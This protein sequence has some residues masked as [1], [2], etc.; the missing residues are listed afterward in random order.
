MLNGLI[1]IQIR[2]LVVKAPV[3][4]I[5]YFGFELVMGVVDNML[6]SKSSTRVAS[7]NNGDDGERSG[8]SWKENGHDNARPQLNFKR[9]KVSAV[10]DFPKG[11]GRSA[12][13]IGSP[14]N[15]NIAN[16]GAHDGTLV[17]G[18]SVED[19]KDKFVST[20]DEPP[21]AND[22]SSKA[23]LVGLEDLESCRNAETVKC[24]SS[25]MSKDLHKNGPSSPVDEAVLLASNLLSRIVSRA[26]DKTV[27]RRNFPKRRVSAT[28]HFPPFCGRNAPRLSKDKLEEL[29]SKDNKI[30]G[31]PALAVDDEE[32]KKVTASDVKEVEKIVE[33]GDAYNPMNM[34]QGDFEEKAM[35]EL[36]EV[37]GFGAS[38]EMKLLP[39]NP[40][41][42]DTALPDGSNHNQELTRP[43]PKI[44][45]ESRYAIQDEGTRG[46]EIVVEESRNARQVEEIL[47][48]EMVVYSGAQSLEAVPISIVE[49]PGDFNELQAPSN[50]VVVLG[51]M[52]ASDCPWRKN[53]ATPKSS[54]VGDKNGRKVKK[55][56]FFARF[57]KSKVA[58]K[59]KNLPS[60]SAK[61]LVVKKKGNC[62]AEGMGQLVV[63]ENKDTLGSDKNME[64]KAVVPISQA[65]DVNVPPLGHRHLTGNDMDSTVTRNKVRE[66]LRLFQVVTRKLLQEEEAK[67]RDKASTS[68]RRID[69]MAARILKDKE[70]YVNTGKAILGVVPGVEVGDEFQYW[71]ELNI[72]GLHRPTQSGIDYVKRDDRILA[73]SVVSSKGYAD[74]SGSSDVLTYTGQGGGILKNGKEPEDQKLERGNLALKNSVVEQNSVRV[75]RGCESTDGKSRRYVYDGLYNVEKY[76]QEKGPHGKLVFRFQMRRIPGQPELAWKEV[77]ECK[78]FKKREGV[79]VDDIS[80]G[81]EPIP[82]CAVNTID[83]EKPPLFEYIT[84]TM[85][86]NWC[87][88]IPLEG[89]SCKY[90]CSD[91]V[92][93]ACAVKNGGEIPYNH[94]GA[95]VE[96]KPLVFECGI[97]CSCPPLCHNRASQHGI[98]FQLEV[99]KTE[100]RGWGV[101]SLNSIPSGSFICEYV[102]ELL[103]EKEAEQRTGNDE[104][105]FDIGNGTNST[106]LRDELSSLMPEAQSSSC[107]I[108]ENHGFTIDAAR[109]GNVGR[110]FNHSCSPNLY[111][112]NVLYDHDDK[113]IP[114]IMFFAAE[115]IPPLQEL[116]YDYNYTIDQVRD[117]DGNIKRKDC[118]CGSAECTGRMY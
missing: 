96:I 18:K 115:N 17:E 47:G 59:S 54:I 94:N 16:S 40:G 92:K 101:R 90:G 8:K 43:P 2:I 23:G 80:N 7:I 84:R 37:D 108:V 117:S 82:I 71:V 21:L 35:Q 107:E 111:A 61:K 26:D 95:I 67:P 89:C 25:K 56:D 41:D 66:T 109:Y 104:Y 50:R 31:Q 20:V 3:V 81:K 11:C 15:V 99:F 65:F 58:T 53:I 6:N 52:S 68:R 85:Y 36:N 38:S 49:S 91:S 62:D 75:I 69:M 105:L 45:E 86:P 22:G 116:C 12:A 100:T 60:C 10:R 97:S 110:F 30:V 13:R 24:D 87:N 118:Y 51:L 9:R 70:K 39:K 27:K 64:E 74:E 55:N 42:K 33:C 77:K 98:K 28:R 88:P 29:S 72:I 14:A 102:G 113:R 83:D 19:L 63:W 114:H 34:V 46:K 106:T 57:D 4:C 112:Q 32:L 76:W 78:K 1:F 103:E 79:C 93:C 48:K 73:S 5:G 44:E